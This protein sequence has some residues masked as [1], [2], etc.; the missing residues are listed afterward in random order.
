METGNFNPDVSLPLPADSGGEK[1]DESKDTSKKKKKKS[2]KTSSH[3]HATRHPDAGKNGE[4]SEDRSRRPPQSLSSL[5]ERI[6]DELKPKEDKKPEEKQQLPETDRRKDGEAVRT[7]ETD[8]LSGDEL[9]EAAEV[10]IDDRQRDVAEELETADEETV[11]SAAARAVD[12]FLDDLRAKLRTPEEPDV[13]EASEA[14]LETV[15]QKYAP[16]AVAAEAA[17]A[18]TPES[19]SGPVS[20]GETADNS[21]PVSQPEIAADADTEG[22]LEIT[23]A[24]EYEDMPPHAADVRAWE[25]LARDTPDNDT[26]MEPDG[27]AAWSGPPLQPGAQGQGGAELPPARRFE[28]APLPDAA[29][30]ET[31]R[32]Q[33]GE[34]YPGIPVSSALIVGFAAYLYGRR[35]GRIKAEHR[36]LPV[37]KQL[38]R[39]VRDVHEKLA[40]QESR[41]RRLVRQQ[42]VLRPVSAAILAVP[43]ERVTHAEALE[44]VQPT[45]AVATAPLEA[46][47]VAAPAVERVVPPQLPEQKAA[48][49]AEAILAAPLAFTAEP[50]HSSAEQQPLQPLSTAPSE[51]RPV[52]LSKEEVFAMPLARPEPIYEPRRV[53]R[54]EAAVVPPAPETPKTVPAAEMTREEVTKAAEQIVVGAATVRQVFETSLISERGMRRVVAE[55][56][57]GGDVRKV[58]AEELMIKEMGYERDP[59]LRDQGPQAATGKATAQTSAQPAQDAS[60]G[61]VGAAARPTAAQPPAHEPPFTFPMGS[62]VPAQGPPARHAPPTIQPALIAANIVAVAILAL[63][64]IVL[65]VLHL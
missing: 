13:D 27:G 60:S 10:Y 63:L 48:I 43:T 24:M 9:R 57:R 5:L 29:V 28:A 8:R 30:H 22:E 49:P 33:D 61:A 21:V 38:E 11:E 52:S 58:L 3:G 42:A 20:T 41:L 59:R 34:Q 17:S 15:A 54:P 16:D 31:A 26:E 35:R 39:Q 6:T 56:Q 45:A 40:A 36:L 18:E 37:Q 19:T 7:S 23:H 1:N 46:V 51:A 32:V 64:L 2:D 12:E 53:A 65:F 44:R 14:S 4:R 50:E 25:L 47:P 62:P 55:Y